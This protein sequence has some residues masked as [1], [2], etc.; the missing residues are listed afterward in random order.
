MWVF[1]VHIYFLCVNLFYTKPLFFHRPIHKQLDDTEYG[2]NKFEYKFEFSKKINHFIFKRSKIAPLC[3]S[4]EMIDVAL[5]FVSGV[6]ELQ[7][8]GVDVSTGCS[9]ES[10][11]RSFEAFVTIYLSITHNI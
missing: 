8:L 4:V 11:V 6:E 7:I 9:T 2:E 5:F 3:I 10:N 1:A